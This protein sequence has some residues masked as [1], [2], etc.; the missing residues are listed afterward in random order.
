MTDGPAERMVFAFN[1]LKARLDAAGVSYTAAAYRDDA[2][3]FLVNEPG[4]YWEI[5]VLEDGTIDVEV[6]RSQ[7]LEDDPWAAIADLIRRNT[8]ESTE[9]KT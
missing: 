1:G 9:G 8:D 3:S 7:G 2:M 6:F 4:Q 5:D